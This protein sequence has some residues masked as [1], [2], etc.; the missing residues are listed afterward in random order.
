[1]RVRQ[2]ARCFSIGRSTL[3]KLLN[4]GLV[5]SV[6]IKNLGALRG[7]RLINADSVRNYLDNLA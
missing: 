1:M 2:T 6:S 3:Y 5:K 7:I 4:K